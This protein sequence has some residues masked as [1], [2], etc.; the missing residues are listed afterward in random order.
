MS[1]RRHQSGC[2]TKIRYRYEALSTNQTFAI[3]SLTSN[4]SDQSA[5]GNICHILPCSIDEDITAPIG[6]Y[7]KPTALPNEMVHKV[8]SQKNDKDGAPEED[9]NKKKNVTIMAAQFRGRGL[10]C[11]VDSPTSSSTDSG[12][13]E[14]EDDNTTSSKPILS[15]LPSNIIGVA[16]SAQSSAGTSNNNTSA[17]S[18]SKDPPMQSLKVVETFNEVYNWS[19]EHDVQKVMRER[20]G[21]DRYGLNAVL[22]WCDL[23]H[24]V[25][26]YYS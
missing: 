24:E 13:S 18:N 9:D 4:M 20:Y 2:T 26:I 3:T 6:Q 5:N 16:L 7:F 11:A 14:E 1:P 22:G 23:S 25:S 17:S 12:S 19:H 10:L 15:K 8:S 21:N